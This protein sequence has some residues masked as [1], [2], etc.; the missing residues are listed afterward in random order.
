MFI[1]T[2]F[3]VKNF[4]IIDI[5]NIFGSV[6]TKKAPWKPIINLKMQ[7]HIVHFFLLWFYRTIF[8]VEYL[9]HFV[10][11]HCLVHIRRL[12]TLLIIFLFLPNILFIFFLFPTVLVLMPPS[13]FLFILLLFIIFSFFINYKTL[14]SFSA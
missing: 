14:Y 13:I 9:K 7:Q 1:K 4:G 12:R 2:I 6:C 5:G 8:Y 3:Y 11:Y 10:N